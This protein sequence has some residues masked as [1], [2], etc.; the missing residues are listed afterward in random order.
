M[1]SIVSWRPD[2]F[3]APQGGEQRARG[4][5][6]TGVQMGECLPFELDAHDGRPLEDYEVAG[7]Y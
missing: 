5:A 7:W 4:P 3:L 1:S 6:S 2:Q